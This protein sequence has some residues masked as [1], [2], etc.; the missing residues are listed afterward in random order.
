MSPKR[1]FFYK[2][3]NSLRLSINYRI[4]LSETVLNILV[5][6]R[7][8]ILRSCK[9]YYFFF[10]SSVLRLGEANIYTKHFSTKNIFMNRLGCCCF[11]KSLVYCSM[12]RM[13]A[14]NCITYRCLEENWLLFVY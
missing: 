8:S 6:D 1:I 13:M 3:D 7:S 4:F 12:C 5:P 11:S 9:S 14:K 10:F 2:S